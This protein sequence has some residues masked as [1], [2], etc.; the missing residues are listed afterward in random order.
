M[1]CPQVLLQDIFQ[2]VVTDNMKHDDT[3]GAWHQSKRV[4]VCKLICSLSLTWS[5]CKMQDDKRM[6]RLRGLT[7]GRSWAI[8][9]WFSST[10]KQSDMLCDVMSHN[11]ALHLPH[12]HKSPSDADITPHTA[13][14]P[15]VCKSNSRDPMTPVYHLGMCGNR[16]QVPT[17]WQDTDNQEHQFSPA[18]GSDDCPGITT[19]V[20]LRAFLHSLLLFVL[21]EWLHSTWCSLCIMLSEASS[22]HKIQYTIYNITYNLPSDTKKGENDS[23]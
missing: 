20:R 9:H 17:I 22:I 2:H 11:T 5:Q 21:M 8:K 13:G 3:T 6:R 18:A 14:V 23:L 4:S 16:V 19:A 10:M 12:G 15:S 1:T 7:V